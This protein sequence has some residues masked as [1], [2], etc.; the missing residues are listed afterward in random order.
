MTD[1]HHAGE[2]ADDPVLDD[3]VS[4][5]D[6]LKRTEEVL[7]ELDAA[8][9]EHRDVQEY[10]PEAVGDSA[11]RFCRERFDSLAGERSHSCDG[12]RHL[13][14][15]EDLGDELIAP[16]L[17]EVGAQWLFD[18]HGLDPYFAV[19]SNFDA[20]LQEDGADG[21]GT[22][23]A[24]GD[25]WRLNHQEDKVKYWEGKI[26]TREGDSGD[27]YYEYNIGVVADDAVGRKRINFQF[28]PAL[29]NAEH[30]DSGGQIGSLPPDLPEG[31]RVQV[32][33][34]N[35]DLEDY[36]DV[37]REL[38]RAMDVNPEYFCEDELHEWSRCYNQAPYVR[39]DRGLSERHVVPRDGLLDRLSSH[40]AQQRGKGRYEWD[41]EEIIGHRNTVAMDAQNLQAFIPDQTVGKLLKSYHMKNPEE[42]LETAT[43]HPKLEVQYSTEFS[44][45]DFESVPWR[46]PDGFDAYDLQEEL[47]EWLLNSLDWAGVS[48]TPDED[49]YVA[50]EYF[51]VE[52]LNEAIDVTLHPDPM[53]V[54][55]EHKRD[56]AEHHIVGSDLT[57]TQKKVLKVAVDGGQQHHEEVAEAA[58]ASSSTVY[59]LA[60]KLGDILRLENG[61]LQVADDVV[62][63]R[64]RDLLQVIERSADW[65]SRSI[66]QIRREADDVDLTE[67]SPLAKWMRT[68][69]VSIDRGGYGRETWTVDIQ[70]GRYRLD[71]IRR[72]LRAGYH[73]A[74]ATG[75]V[76]SDYFLE[77]TFLW[78]DQDGSAQRRE[79]AFTITPPQLRALGMPVS[80]I[81]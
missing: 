56:L 47:V 24:A 51:A 3:V 44:F 70:V 57:E 66:G 16:Q 39:L 74:R 8:T 54:L 35:V 2:D 30:V 64:C 60:E 12:R 32:D 69:G 9:P 73:A 67:D 26:A 79:K 43:A 81:A 1:R 18:R 80:D 38:M 22:F 48:L 14:H 13:D 55:E 59:R 23:E 31:I 7:D 78:T 28:R 75:A 36:I 45:G 46:D 71:E 33:G 41:N 61:L 63:E 42:S 27:A 5:A 72:V 11:C 77:A 49:I 21:V 10:P 52:G 34:A 50:D 68:Y 40:A 62:R 19:V 29:P 17:H 53:P 25:T 76:V 65:V 4:D 58:G 6:S 20:C 37:L 15:L